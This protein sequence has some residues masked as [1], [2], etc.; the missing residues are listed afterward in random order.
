MWFPARTRRSPLVALLE[1]H[2]AAAL[3]ARRIGGVGLKKRSDEPRPRAADAT[4]RVNARETADK[5]IL[6]SD[7]GDGSLSA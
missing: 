5:R 2:L 6:C 3:D 7:R 1:R 4:E